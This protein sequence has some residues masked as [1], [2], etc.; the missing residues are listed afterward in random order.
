MEVTMKKFA[1]SMIIAI[2][3]TGTALAQEPVWD[4]NKIVLK[5]QKLAEG[6]FAVVPTGADEM[7]DNGLPIATSSG[8]VIGTKSVLV[9]DTMLNKRLNKQLMQLIS[10]QTDLPVRYAVNTSFHGDHAYGNQYLPEKNHDYP[11]QSR[12]ELHSQ[13]P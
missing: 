11:A 13:A 2:G 9:I 8:F 4:G 3:F 6:I 7:A 10:D 5:S 12:I 1:L